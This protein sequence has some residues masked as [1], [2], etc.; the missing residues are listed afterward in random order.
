VFPF[1]KAAL[2]SLFAQI[3]FIKIFSICCS[4]LSPTGTQTVAAENPEEEADVTVPPTLPGRQVRNWRQE[5]HSEH[6]V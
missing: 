4:R 3:Q 1:S 2:L 5:F 6:D